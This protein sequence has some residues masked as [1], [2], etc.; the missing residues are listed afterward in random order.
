MKTNKQIHLFSFWE[1]LWHDNLLTVIS[2]Y[3]FIYHLAASTYYLT[4][5]LPSRVLAYKY[6]KQKSFFFLVYFLYETPYYLQRA[7]FLN[8]QEMN[9]GPPL[10]AEN[11]WFWFDIYLWFITHGWYGIDL[12]L[13]PKYLVVPFLRSFRSK[14]FGFGIRNQNQGSILVLVLESIF[15][16][17]TC[18][19]RSKESLFSAKKNVLF[20]LL[21]FSLF[22]H[23]FI[24]SLDIFK[25]CINSYHIESKQV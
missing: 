3:T 14:R 22:H 6:E 4:Y 21:N 16:R 18:S 15:D 9:L 8:P 24:S 13:F 11:V 12:R 23:V 10:T 17:L 1:N 2:L 7:D 25:N 19:K 5:F 20:H